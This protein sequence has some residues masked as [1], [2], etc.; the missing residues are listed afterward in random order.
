MC[1]VYLLLYLNILLSTCIRS[2]THRTYYMILKKN[3]YTWR[4]KGSDITHIYKIFKV[5]CFASN[6]T[7]V[8]DYLSLLLCLALD[9]SPVV[10]SFG[11]LHSVPKLPQHRVTY[12]LVCTLLCC[13]LVVS[14][15]YTDQGCSVVE[16]TP[17]WMSLPKR[18]PTCIRCARVGS[19]VSRSS[20]GT[21]AR[22]PPLSDVTMTSPLLPVQPGRPCML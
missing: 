6:V 19:D 13:R 5:I 14:T 9:P 10:C 15:L 20:R 12:F 1:R 4:R 7:L 3:T 21:Q 11:L 16:R 18:L 22:G 17:A 8:L 2:G